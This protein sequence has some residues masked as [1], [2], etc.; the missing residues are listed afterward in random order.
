MY[1]YKPKKNELFCKDAHAL[2][3]IHY[4]GIREDKSEVYSQQTKAAL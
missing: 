1:R 3:V 4:V 2:E